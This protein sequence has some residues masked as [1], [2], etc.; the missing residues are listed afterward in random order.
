MTIM[1]TKAG[2]DRKCAL[3]EEDDTLQDVYVA[4][5]ASHAETHLVLDRH[6][7]R[8]LE[9]KVRERRDQVAMPILH[10]IIFEV[11]S[12]IEIKLIVVHGICCG[13]VKK[14]SVSAMNIF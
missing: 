6:R 4:K 3:C 14:I 1:G 9:K 2:D 11:L 5:S 7:P 10:K 8:T 13:I 12:L